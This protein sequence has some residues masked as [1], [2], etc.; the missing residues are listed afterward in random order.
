MELLVD[1]DYHVAFDAL[2][3]E[4]YDV[5][6]VRQDVLFIIPSPYPFHKLVDSGVGWRADQR[7]TAESLADAHQGR[8]EGTLGVYI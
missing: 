6:F 5:D 7:R 8:K 3:V 4:A 1:P 2:V